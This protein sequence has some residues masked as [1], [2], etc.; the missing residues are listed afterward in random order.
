MPRLS[1][2]T[3]ARLMPLLDG[4]DQVPG[5]IQ[6]K[7]AIFYYRRLHML[8]FHEA[9]RDENVESLVADLKCVVPEPSGFD[10]MTIAGAA[11]KQRLIKE[12]TVRCESLLAPPAVK[13]G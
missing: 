11:D 2:S 5:L 4:L 8:H 1:S 9:P 12:V 10:R 6:V 7:P 3:L 13:R